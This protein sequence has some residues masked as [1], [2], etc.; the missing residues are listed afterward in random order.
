MAARSLFRRT[1]FHGYAVQYFS[2]MAEAAVHIYV[3]TD[4]GKYPVFIPGLMFIEKFLPCGPKGAQKREK[5]YKDKQEV[6]P[7]RNRIS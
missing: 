3:L 7:R 1:H 4:R 2:F 5:A 6:Y